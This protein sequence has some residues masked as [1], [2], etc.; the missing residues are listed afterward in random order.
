M[1]SD[2]ALVHPGPKSSISGLKAAVATGCA[3]TVAEG[4]V[5]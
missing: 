2:P 1:P 3:N 5:A 4:T